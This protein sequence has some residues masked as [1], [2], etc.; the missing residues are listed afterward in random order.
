MLTSWNQRWKCWRAA[1]YVQP[2][3]LMLR[4]GCP[5]LRWEMILLNWPKS[6]ARVCFPGG[7]HLWQMMGPIQT[8]LWV[9]SS[10]NNTIYRLTVPI[11]DSWADNMFCNLGLIDWFSFPSN[12]WRSYLSMFGLFGW[13]RVDSFWLEQGY[14]ATSATRLP[15]AAAVL[16]P[17][18]SSRQ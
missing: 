8:H 17:N 16:N 5:R 7:K 14:C 12:L 10:R 9:A 15:L 1:S 3:Q 11:P 13:G 18:P 4:T 6:S 2:W